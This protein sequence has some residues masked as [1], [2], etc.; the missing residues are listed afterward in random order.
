MGIEMG[1]MWMRWRG[2][3]D[4][5]DGDG[6]RDDG[7][8]IHG[9]DGDWHGNGTGANEDRDGEGGVGET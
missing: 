6:D 8:D 7:D 2:W 4:A 5:E 1:R 3:W 9:E